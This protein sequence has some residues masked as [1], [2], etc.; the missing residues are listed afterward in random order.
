MGDILKTDYGYFRGIDVG[1]G[2]LFVPASDPAP[3]FGAPNP[4]QAGLQTQICEKCGAS[5]VPRSAENSQ[6]YLSGRIPCDWRA[7]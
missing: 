4:L 2:Q 6:H 5:F 7:R 1:H 3:A